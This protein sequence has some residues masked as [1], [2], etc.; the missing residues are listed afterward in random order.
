M[1][2][3]NERSEELFN[4]LSRN[5]KEKK[6]KLL[7]TVISIIVIIAVILVGTVIQLRNKVDDKFAVTGAQVLTYEV[8]TGTI[9][10]LVSGTGTLT[11][12]DLETLTVPNGV[13]VTEVIAQRD[14]EVAKG[15]LLA[16]VDMSTVLTALADLQT[17]LDDLDQQIADA[18][19]D[20]VNRYI[21][22]GISGR[23]KR[24]LAEEGMD[25][26][27][28]MAQHG[29]LAVLSLDGY[30]AVDLETDILSRGDSV[31]VIREDGTE[32]TGKVDTVANKKATILVSDNGPVYGETVTVV[33]EDG[34]QVGSGT[35]YIHSPLAVTGYAG[36][37]SMVHVKENAAVYPATTL[38]SLKNT[39][40]TAN[41]DT[42][43]RQRSELEEELLLLLTIYRDGAIL[44]PMDG[45][46]SSIEFG[47]ESPSSLLYATVQTESEETKLLTI[48]PNISMSVTIGIDEGDILNLELGQEASVKVSS[49]SEEV[50]SGKV[51]KI[52]K[53]AD[54]S[55]GV[56]QYSAQVTL[57]KAAGMLPGMTASVDISIEGVENA[58]IIPVDA[59]HQTSATAFVYTSYDPETQ[60]YGDMVNVTTGMQNDDYVEILSGLNIGDTIYY[61]EKF[62]SFFDF[63]MGAMG[64]R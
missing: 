45:V 55:T 54:I 10:A 59:L 9:H 50:F 41:Y 49:V 13:D 17:Q 43:L 57:D 20:E 52:S 27:A 21:S 61:T 48:Y 24:I 58:M 39:S 30:M 2:N 3:Q 8:T 32:I 11:Q 31:T 42:L 23:I 26:S 28:C 36:T 12:V 35:L 14:Q 44:S 47:E 64:R 1:S 37:I 4:T 22:A 16:T 34:N 5:K 38:F 19:G 15:D 53:D 33:T 25:V 40:F 51:T 46:V 6:R 63:A 62:D 29:A 18:K 60:E 7:R 56:T